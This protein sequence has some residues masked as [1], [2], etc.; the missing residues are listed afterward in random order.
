MLCGEVVAKV[1]LQIGHVSQN[2][3]RFFFCGM[4]PPIP[5]DVNFR[6]PMNRLLYEEA[7]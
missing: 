6:R 1:R 2:V 3:Y 4:P 7:R 5:R